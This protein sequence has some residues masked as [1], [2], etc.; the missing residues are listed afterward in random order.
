MRPVRH[1]DDD[2]GGGEKGGKGG[3]EG[4]AGSE[5]STGDDG[6]VAVVNIEKTVDAC[7]GTGG[8]GD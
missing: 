6:S 2:E 5:T 8:K 3:K 7:A 4:G 1:D